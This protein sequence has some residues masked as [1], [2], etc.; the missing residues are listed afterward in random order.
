MNYVY[1]MAAHFCMHITLRAHVMCARRAVSEHS[2]RV[3]C[4]RSVRA[5]GAVNA[6]ALYAEICICANLLAYALALFTSFE[7]LT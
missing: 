2:S 7:V 1:A 6:S 3:L 5:C 4:V